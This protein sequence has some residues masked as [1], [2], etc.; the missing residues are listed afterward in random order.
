MKS[1]QTTYELDKFLTEVWELLT[2]EA[3]ESMYV[4]KDGF[5]EGVKESLD[6]YEK[7]KNDRSGIVRMSREIIGMER[8]EDGG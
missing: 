4:V 6:E 5:M 1:K 8:V 2:D 7:C 3:R